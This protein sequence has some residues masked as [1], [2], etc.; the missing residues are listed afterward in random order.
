MNKKIFLVKIIFFDQLIKLIKASYYQRLFK[1]LV[2]DNSYTMKELNLEKNK[3]SIEY[4]IKE[5]FSS[6]N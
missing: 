5:I 3:Y 1:S 4:G 2:I 6:N